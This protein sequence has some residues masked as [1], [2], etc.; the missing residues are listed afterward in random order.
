MTGIA[1]ELDE[2][3]MTGIVD[4]R[5]D[6][7][8]ELLMTGLTGLA[9]LAG[10]LIFERLVEQDVQVQVDVDEHLLVLLDVHDEQVHMGEDEHLLL[11]VREYS[12]VDDIYITI[13]YNT[14]LCYISL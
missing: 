14:V 11:S 7:L 6:E 4:E 1:D 9:G 10:L 3:L 8:D 2:L 13:I 5:L 12:T